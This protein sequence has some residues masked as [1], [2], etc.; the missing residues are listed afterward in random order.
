[1]E[2]DK[3]SFLYLGFVLSALAYAVAIFFTPVLCVE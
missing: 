1:M 2:Q 3:I